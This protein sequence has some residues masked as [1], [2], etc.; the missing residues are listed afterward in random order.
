MKKPTGEIR[1]G[2]IT[3]LFTFHGTE[4]KEVAEALA[5]DIVMVAGL[6]DI[7]IGETICSNESQVPLPAINIDEPTISLNFLVNDSPLAGRDGK[8]VTTRQIKERLEKEL[9]INVGLKIDFTANEF[10]KVY[11][12]GELHIAILLENM[13][14]EGFELQVSQPQVII[15]EE[16]GQK[17]EPFEEVIIDLPKELAGPIIETLGRRKGIMM[18]MKEE[19]GSIIRLVFEAPTRGILGYK[20]QFTIDTKGEG[21]MCSRFI[22]FRPYAGEIKKRDTGSMTSMASGKA[23][24]F[25]LFN[26]QPRGALYVEPNTELYEGMVIGNT[27]KGDELA[28]NPTKGKQLT[29]VR[30]G[31]QADEK[32]VLAPALKMTLERGLEIMA[33]DE[34]LEVTPLNVRL[35]KQYLKESE[36]KIPKGR[37]KKMLYWRYG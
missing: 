14:R 6:P 29:N 12:R 35:R 31:G 1:N 16:N 15:K 4:R 26:L 3:K 24:A 28:V 32:I 36:R 5:G 20:N 9:E 21:I 22:G 30:M 18:Q 25:S 10:F 17:M 7:Y 11:G 19:Q 34:Y 2:K 13:R 33:E 27:M 23:V 8:F 37:N